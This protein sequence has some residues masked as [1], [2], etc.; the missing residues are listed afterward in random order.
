[1][2]NTTEAIASNSPLEELLPLLQR[3]DQLLEQAIAAAQIAYGTEAAQY[4]YR[5]LHV[6]PE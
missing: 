3:L 6:N 4:P 1:M 5:G 2:V